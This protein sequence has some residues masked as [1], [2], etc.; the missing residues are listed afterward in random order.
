M[1][2]AWTEK[3]MKTLKEV[4]PVKEPKIVTC[5]FTEQKRQCQLL[6]KQN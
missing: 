6:E 2:E 3:E 1:K 5:C 4:Y